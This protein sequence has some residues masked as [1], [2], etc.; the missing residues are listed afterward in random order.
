MT[1]IVKSNLCLLAVNLSL[2]ASPILFAGKGCLNCFRSGSADVDAAE[3]PE[4]PLFPTAL[5]EEEKQ[6]FDA[7]ISRE[8]NE[9][10]KTLLQEL[11]E[12][13]FVPTKSLVLGGHTFYLCDRIIL[14]TSKIKRVQ[15]I[16]YAQMENGRY[17]PRFVYL[18]RSYGDWR[19]SPFPHPYQYSKGTHVHYT[20][21]TTLADEFSVEYW[22]QYEEATRDGKILPTYDKS[23]IGAEELASFVGEVPP[24]PLPSR[25]QSPEPSRPQSPEPSRPQSPEPRSMSLD[26]S[27]AML[28]DDTG[29][30]KESK[31]YNDGGFLSFLQDESASPGQ[32]GN[33][34]TV[35]A[36]FKKISRK[37]KKN[38]S[39][40]GFMPDFSQPPVKEF[41]ASHLVPQGKEPALTKQIT[42][43]VYKGL[44]KGEEI[45]WYMCNDEE[46]R[47]WIEKIIFADRKLTSFATPSR[48]INSGPLTNKPLEYLHQT[49]KWKWKKEKLKFAGDAEYVDIT[50]AL[51]MLWPIQKYREA[52]KLKR[53]K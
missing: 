46:N 35:T 40:R 33:N 8:P 7:A 6:E 50:P 45:L 42:V 10:L 28:G 20:Q 14:S 2:T 32:M 16:F 12:G 34:S 52:L 37:L 9:K 39:L 24:S 29:F 49:K 43:R 15:T 18:S 30:E 44:L 21:E 3:L 19:L 53:S 17:H 26:F 25:P 41:N 38:R 47:I 13:G 11:R 36:D 51:D 48:V 23:L 1:K 5:T 27:N 4:V 22:R 31:I